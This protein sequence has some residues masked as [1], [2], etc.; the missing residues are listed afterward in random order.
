MTVTPI[1]PGAT[2]MFPQKKCNA[3]ENL[4]GSKFHAGIGKRISSGKM[5]KLPVHA[6]QSATKSQT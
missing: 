6:K 3:S 5:F 1:N 2:Q 4:R